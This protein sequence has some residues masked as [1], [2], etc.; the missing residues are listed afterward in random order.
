MLTYASETWVLNKQ[1]IRTLG[2]F[3]RKKMMENDGWRI[4]YNNELYELH[5]E[6]DIVTYIKIGRFQWAGHLIRMEDERPA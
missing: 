1:D 5:G 3:E 2:V 6:P 4:K